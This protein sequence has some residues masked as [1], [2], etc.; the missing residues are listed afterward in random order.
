MKS[1]KAILA[2]LFACIFLSCAESSDSDTLS[3]P[4]VQVSLALE[5][6]SKT[7]EAL[8]MPVV[9]T[10]GFWDS[11]TN[12]YKQDKNRVR[13]SLLA[14]DNFNGE[15]NLTLE[16]AVWMLVE[17]GDFS[18]DSIVGTFEKSDINEVT[19]IKDGVDYVASNFDLTLSKVEG[20]T[21]TATLSAICHPQNTESEQDISIT[22]SISGRLNLGCVAQTEEND[23]VKDEAWVENPN[24]CAETVK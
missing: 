6:E 9:V 3:E 5:G 1:K 14:T 22:A 21:A 13:V 16:F 19:L 17:P 12:T 8:S 4:E 20:E 10:E 2:G 18:V 7:L 23:A 15:P 24:F 11:E